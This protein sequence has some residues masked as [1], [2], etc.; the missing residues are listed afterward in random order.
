MRDA[1]SI[2]TLLLI[3]IETSSMLRFESPFMINSVVEHATLSVMSE[4]WPAQSRFSASLSEEHSR[5]RDALLPLLDSP[6]AAIRK[7]ATLCLGQYR[8]SILM[9]EHQDDPAWC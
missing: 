2:W 4:A 8:M 7:R 3:H 1:F 6:R 5:M 9:E